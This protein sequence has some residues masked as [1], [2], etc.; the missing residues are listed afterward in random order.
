M[1]TGILLVFT[2]GLLVFVFNKLRKTE[3][4]LIEFRKQAEEAFEVTSNVDNIIS[5]TAMTEEIM[6]H[7]DDIMAPVG[8][9]SKQ[10]DEIL[11]RLRDPAA[12]SS[13]NYFD[14]F[15]EKE[16]KHRIDLDIHI[17]KS[18]FFKKRMDHIDDD[19]AVGIAMWNRAVNLHPDNLCASFILC[20]TS[21]DREIM[22][23]HINYAKKVF[24]AA[25]YTYPK[26]CDPAFT[27]SKEEIDEELKRD[28][29]VKAIASMYESLN[30]QAKPT[31]N[32]DKDTEDV[33]EE[34]D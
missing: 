28:A 30:T 17:V 19:D 15:A 12:E 8:V 29:E 31:I 14:Q 13:V 16:E 34:T 4:N 24:R 10:I 9:M 32:L 5:T 3:Q 26:N 1:F 21:S 22:Q 18:N 33:E 7:V 2:S 11:L 25:G 20:D 27:P 6:K 23:G